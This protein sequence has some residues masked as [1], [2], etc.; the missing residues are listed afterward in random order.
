MVRG[1]FAT[2]ILFP[3]LIIAKVSIAQT[4][5][6]ASQPTNAA[7]A[8]QADPALRAYYAGNGLLNR[9]MFEAAIAE[10]RSFLA[11]SPNHEKATVA[12][13]GLVVSLFRLE[14]CD[15]ALAELESLRDAKD[16]AYAAEVGMIEGQC[17]MSKEHFAA[18]VRVF[19]SIAERFADSEL[20]DD[21]AVSHCEALYRAAD[22][23][24]AAKQCQDVASRWPDS[25][26]LVRS[27]FFLALAEM[28]RKDF[29]AASKVLLAYEKKFPKSEFAAQIPLLLAQC[30]QR[31]DETEKAIER[32]AAV[33][34]GGDPNQVP[35][36]LLGLGSL[37]Y[38]S[39]KYVE[40][41]KALDTLLTKF[42]DTPAAK[43]AIMQRAH[44]WFAQGEFD[45]ALAAFEQAGRADK[46][47]AADVAYWMAKCELRKG[48]HAAAAKRLARAVDQFPDSPLLPEMEYDCAV[49]LLRAEKLDDAV[50]ALD[51]FLVRHTQHRLLADALQ[52]AAACEHQRGKF[53][54][55]AARCSEFAT[56]FPQHDAL[57]AVLLIAA[58]N[59]FLTGR[60][61]EAAKQYLSFLQRFPEDP[62][63]D[64]SRLRLAMALY[65]L[66]KFDE[67]APYFEQL[68][69]KGKTNESFR[70]A[71]LAL[72][73]IAFQRGEWKN[74]ERKLGDYLAMDLKAPG[75]DDAIM[76][77]AYARQKQDRIDQALR[78]YQQLIE[79]FPASPHRVQALFEIGQILAVAK[80]N[81]EAEDSLKKALA[82]GGDSRF[83][84]PILTQLAAL[85]TQRGAHEEAAR[86]YEQA[87]SKAG[88]G[89][90]G[91]AAFLRQG[92]SLMAAGNLSGAQAAFQKAK[93]AEGTA[94]LAIALARQ[95]RHAEALAEINRLEA[96]G[97]LPGLA[98]ALREGVRYEKAWAL[99]S[100]NKKDEAAAIYREMIAEEESGPL[101][102]SAML[103]LA[104]LESAEKRFD[105]AAA[106]LRQLQE[107][108]SSQPDAAANLAE[109]CIYRLG[110]CEFELEHFAPAAE[111]FERFAR[112]FP[113]STLL[114]SALF[115][116]GE[117][118]FRAGRIDRAARML[119]TVVDEHSTP[120][121][122][123]P[124]M[125]RLG[126][127]HAVLQKWAQSEET[128]QRFLE[129][130]PEAE[131]WYQAQFG[132]GWS[133]ENQKRYDE[134]VAAYEKVTARH[135]G[136]TAA[137]AQFQIGQCHFAQKKYEPAIRELLKVDILYA[138]PEWSAAALYEAGR[139]FAQLND[140]AQARQQ[141]NAVVEKFKDSK[142]AE[143]A[144]RQL[145]E[146][147]SS[148]AL[149]GK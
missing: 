32:Y 43:A 102:P 55:S 21:A 9:G 23:D 14:E 2:A 148:A 108:L 57:S 107:L 127:C 84:V 112:D 46:S 30:F 90:D 82:E 87:A 115:Y 99:R 27:E 79:A 86:Y 34:K 69:V 38:Q 143:M 117:A 75:A 73:D 74:A 97:E 128:F 146:L 39:G 126:E 60:H 63:A 1:L 13:Y 37:L 66:E 119:A 78:D 11:A 72:G 134:A 36:G 91:N 12:R 131:Q 80:K 65:R 54:R 20:A 40:A 96:S 125:L 105:S 5:S 25:P 10:Y 85:A 94:R 6:P 76:K 116:A 35:D 110:I 67:A 122:L 15:E 24:T 62:M 70:P 18:A 68:A 50:E 28:A 101:Q 22:F 100:L 81:T 41:G 47:A 4:S 106:L 19:E 141:F 92:Q 142:W 111:L 17:Y 61:E 139:C 147:T 64:E 77:L 52:L 16:F 145:A 88:A 58:E 113:K 59:E 83:V 53:D 89:D 7:Q 130:F 135:Q 95:D 137:R 26:L 45:K 121:L 44:V 71:L 123:A 31:G 49:A 42:A 8:G 56:K 118:N 140:P 136:P 129:R 124:A 33:V 3:V 132:V 48:D 138:Y 109:Q 51:K 29:A 144:A 133:R 149:P 104:E 120:E 114:A 93:S 103:E 98:P